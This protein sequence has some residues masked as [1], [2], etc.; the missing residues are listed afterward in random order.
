MDHNI[1]N[2]LGTELTIFTLSLWVL[3]RILNNVELGDI[4][5]WIAIASGSIAIFVNWPR[6]VKRLKGISRKYF[7]KKTKS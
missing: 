2:D 7:S 5:N 4:T 1:N 6:V 3:G